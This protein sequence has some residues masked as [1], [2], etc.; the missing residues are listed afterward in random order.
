MLKHNLFGLVFIC[1]ILVSC[2]RQEQTFPSGDDPDKFSADFKIYETFYNGHKVA[3]D[4]VV[5][6]EALMRYEGG[7]SDFRWQVGSTE[8]YTPD[9][10]LRFGEEDM[11]A[12]IPVTLYAKKNFYINGVPVVKADTVTRMLHLKA[13][14][15]YTVA[16]TLSAEKVVKI[17]YLGSFKGS[18]T[19]APGYSFTIYIAYQGST[20]GSQG[21][22]DW[23]GLRIY[24]LPE[25][26]GTGAVREPCGTFTESDLPKRNYAPEV[27]PGYLGFTAEGGANAPGSCC[28]EINASGV[29][30]N[31]A[32]D[33]IRIDCKVN[34]GGGPVQ[35][36]VWLGKRI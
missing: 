11:E 20:Y 13:L 8:Y 18:F 22:G 36:R 30:T 32:R 35:N 3:T 33:S 12:P 5:R 17:P 1:S 16:Q 6:F 31:D 24:N 29:L 28:P 7:F 14:E 15:T 4:T 27:N 2:K 25:G 26:C 10:L 34:Y 19:D 9:L 23:R 21:D